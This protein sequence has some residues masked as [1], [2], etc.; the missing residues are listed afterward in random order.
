LYRDDKYKWRRLLKKV[1]A[2]RCRFNIILRFNQSIQQAL[3]CMHLDS[4]FSCPDEEIDQ[5]EHTDA[6]AIG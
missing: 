5:S 2:N 1:N 6:D 3:P 4:L